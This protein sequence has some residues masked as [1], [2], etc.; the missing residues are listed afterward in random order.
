MSYAII[1]YIIYIMLPRRWGEDM[2]NQKRT[3][4]LYIFLLHC[5]GVDLV[6]ILDSL[7]FNMVLKP[8]IGYYRPWDLLLFTYILLLCVNR[9][10]FLG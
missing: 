1:L 5:R 4:G 6:T 2:Y 3:I 9:R 10:R 7:R 8:S